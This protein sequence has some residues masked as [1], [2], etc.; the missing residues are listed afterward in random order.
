[1]AEEKK[2]R[3]VD[4][5][6]GVT[7]EEAQLFKH[8]THCDTIEELFSSIEENYKRGSGRIGEDKPVSQWKRAIKIY[9][10]D[11]YD[12]LTEK[13]DRAIVKAFSFAHY[14]EIKRNIEELLLNGS[15]SWEYFSKSGNSLCYNSEIEERI[16]PPS[17]RGKYGSER[18]LSMQA[19]ALR[20][21]AA[22]IA[23]KLAPVVDWNE[24]RGW[25]IAVKVY[26]EEGHRQRASFGH[27]SFYDFGK[28][29]FLTRKVNVLKEDVNKTN[30]YAIIICDC[31]TRREVCH[32]A[33]GQLHDG[34]FENC[35]I[36]KCE[37][38]FYG[39]I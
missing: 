28:K 13:S 30:D 25:R 37:T 31:D 10:K 27:S 26:G 20:E 22:N 23:H 9:E 5:V 36:G 34:A 16:L 21:A 1:M 6:E 32:E 19:E 12:S 33:I 8:G 17:Q 2:E 3:L 38:V 15:D 4:E 39:K 14:D 29:G 24:F 7:K 11:L 35:R 18:L